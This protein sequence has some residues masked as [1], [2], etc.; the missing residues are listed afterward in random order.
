MSSDEKPT[1]KLLLHRLQTEGIA[2]DPAVRLSAVLD[3]VPT[4]E[5]VLPDF[6]RSLG[7]NLDA[8][9]VRRELLAILQAARH[10]LEV[11]L[12]SNETAPRH[13][14]KTDQPAWLW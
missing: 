6:A 13:R 10:E 4:P 8:P 3:R 9:E 11:A 2:I 7:A 14:E 1:I 12:R 5:Q